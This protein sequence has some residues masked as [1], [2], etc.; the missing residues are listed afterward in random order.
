MKSLITF[1]LLFILSQSFITVK[2]RAGEHKWLFWN[3]KVKAGDGVKYI[4]TQ[5]EEEYLKLIAKSAKKDKITPRDIAAY[6]ET[7]VEDIKIIDSC[8]S[9]LVQNYYGISM[10]HQFAK[11]GEPVD[12]R[13]IDHN[14]ECDT[15][16]F[17]INEP[18]VDS[19]CKKYKDIL[20]ND[21]GDFNCNSVSKILMMLHGQV[22]DIDNIC[23]KQSQFASLI[24]TQD[25]ISESL[26]TIDSQI[27]AIDESK[28]TM[29]SDFERAKD[30]N[31]PVLNY[32]LDRQTENYSKVLEIAKKELELERAK[33]INSDKPTAISA[34]TH[35]T[36]PA[37]IDKLYGEL[38]ISIDPKNESDDGED[39]KFIEELV[40]KEKE[41]SRVK[42]SK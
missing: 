8:Y 31:N 11:D 12:K 13:K 39:R 35:V 25:Q 21:R 41:E 6:R 18:D 23:A 22:E 33:T 3:S 5:N 20:I 24:D 4:R 19:S 29:I 10:Y 34:F 30:P 26:A 40:K 7:R 9:Y 42:A 14:G 32:F 28:A 36:Y 16:I 2:A 38:I 37:K 15:E 27:A 1:T 17:N